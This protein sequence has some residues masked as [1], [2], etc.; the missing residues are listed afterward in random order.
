MGSRKGSNPYFYGRGLSI[1]K[2]MHAA[3]LIPLKVLE[4][5]LISPMKMILHIMKK[6]LDAIHSVI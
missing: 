2:Y 1:P 5:M 4:M 3:E 6:Y